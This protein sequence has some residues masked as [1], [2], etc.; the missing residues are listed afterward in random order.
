M[1]YIFCVFICVICYTYFMRQQN[2]LLYDISD[3]DIHWRWCAGIKQI[4]AYYN[5]DFFILG[6]LFLDDLRL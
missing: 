4:F 3:I 2:I 5:S 1:P 6:L